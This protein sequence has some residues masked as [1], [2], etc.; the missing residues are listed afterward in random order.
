MLPLEIGIRVQPGGAFSSYAAE[1]LKVGDSLQVMPPFGRFHANIDPGAAHTYFAFAAGSGIT[2]ILSIIRATLECESGSRFV[3]FYGNRSQKSTMFVD[4]LF[5]LKNRF[6]DRLQLNFLF[7]REEQEFSILGGRLDADKTRKLYEQFCTEL[8]PTAVF[9]CGPDTMIATVTEVL[10]SLGIDERAI[11]TERFG[12]ARKRKAP[13]APIEAATDTGKR[14]RVSVILDGH[15]QS[16]EMPAEGISILDA[17]AE[18]GI[19]LPYSCKGGSRALSG[20][21]SSPRAHCSN[22]S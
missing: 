21:N 19:E 9:I 13:Q 1:K 17:A 20:P 6:P 10:S 5:A 18:H 15:R 14:V 4:D 3:L 22:S 11:H 2:P 8:N 7:S 16:F 12:A